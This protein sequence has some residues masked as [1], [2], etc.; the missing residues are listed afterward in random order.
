MTV[1][2]TM[3]TIL[4]PRVESPMMTTILRP[5]VESPMMMTMLLPRVESHALIMT[6]MTTKS[7]DDDDAPSKSGKSI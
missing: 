7:Y 5:R 6:V 2:T 3:T 4:R 1:M